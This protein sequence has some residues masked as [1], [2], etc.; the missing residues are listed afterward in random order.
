M[1]AQ[2]AHGAA[3]KGCARRKRT[4][5]GRPGNALGGRPAA[6]SY[7]FLRAIFCM[8]L[9]TFSQASQH[10]SMCENMLFHAMR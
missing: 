1:I 10:S 5:A 6:G 3:S 4:S 9:A 7:V 2:R 8:T